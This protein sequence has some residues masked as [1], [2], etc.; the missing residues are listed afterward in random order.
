[1]TLYTYIVNHKISKILVKNTFDCLLCTPRRQKLG[2]IINIAYDNYFLV[3]TKA[4][5][6][7]VVFLPTALLFVNLSAGLALA[8]VD[9]FM[10]TQLDNGVRVYGNVAVVEEI[11]KLLMEYFSI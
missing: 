8:P 11:S 5:F 3:D 9:I 6:D 2:H 1:M 4:G 10:K 7:L